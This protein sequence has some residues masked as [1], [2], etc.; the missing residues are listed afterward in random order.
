MI[1]RILIISLALLGGVS[2][3]AVAQS[4]P[5]SANRVDEPLSLQEF[6]G[7]IVK[8][9]ELVRVQQLEVGIADESL[10]GANAIFEPYGT[11]SVERQG[12]FTKNTAV[13]QAQRSSSAEYRSSENIRK[14]GLGMKVPT[15]ADVEVS[16]NIDEIRN[17]VQQ[18]SATSTTPEFKGYMGFKITQPL[19]K[20]GGVDAT[21][22]SINAAET[23]KATAVEM[24]RQVKTQ[25][26]MEGIT[27]YLMV[28]R[29]QERVR[30]RTKSQE[31][32]ERLLVTV[33]EQEKLGL[34][35]SSEV[36]DAEATA[37]LRRSQ[38]SQAQQELEEQSAQ[39]QILL[40]AR[41]RADGIPAKARRYSTADRLELITLPVERIPEDGEDA[42]QD[43]IRDSLSRRPETQVAKH[44]IQ[45]EDIRI[46]YAENQ[47]L[48]ELNLTVRRGFET[49]DDRGRSAY[50]I[51]GDH[52]F[53]NSWYMGLEAK[54]YLQGDIKRDSEVRAARMKRE[55][56]KLAQ[57]AAEQKIA[58]EVESS[59]IIMDRSLAQVKRQQEIVDAQ[60]RLLTIETQ[61]EGEGKRSAVDLMRKQ[62]ESLM[63][64]EALA[65]SI[66]VANR[67]SYN[68]LQARGVVLAQVGME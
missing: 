18:T 65:D 1:R 36:L 12:Q 6:L 44:R 24:S 68:L 47:A 35:S 63:A 23:D 37:S 9:D 20:N 7:Q 17:S 21:M 43:A 14:Y 19:L 27:A 4:R 2:H 45:R 56:A 11:M 51:A 55:Q 40:A 60:H 48:P 46:D 8:S 53:Y 31:V 66:T 26:V 33:R 38:L 62:L 34:R 39:L 15:G 49:L 64:E 52:G 58:N 57:Q 32:A 54:F 5:S 28:Q 29:A 67:A 30:L 42:M 10:R 22:S 59:Q 61:M 41:D 50:D 3:G 25:R 16:Y 13:E